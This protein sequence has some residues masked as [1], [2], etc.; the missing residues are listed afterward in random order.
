MKRVAEGGG[1]MTVIGLALIG[2]TFALFSGCALFEDERTTKGRK[3][4]N[5]YCSHCHGESGQQGEGFNWDRMPDPRPKNLA[6]NAEM[7]TF[8]DE[9]IFHTVYRD[10][11]DTSDQKVLNDE[12][13]FAVPTMPTFKYTLSEEEIW[14]IVGYV[15]TLHGMSLTYDLEGRRKELEQ[16]LQAA[17]P[18]METAK[19]AYDAAMEKF[20]AE[21]AAY[22][23]TLTDA[24]LENY[25]PK[26]VTLP[27]ETAFLAANEKYELA[28]AELENF[29][30][31]P[32]KA[33]VSRPELSL[34]GEGR[35]QQAELGKQLYSL[36]Y[37]CNGC[38]SLNDEGGLVGPALDRAGFRL[39]PTWIYRWIL[40]PQAMKKHTR[41]PN[42]G[43]SEQDAKALTYYLETLQAPKPENPSPSVE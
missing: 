29:T 36:K 10:M 16:A 23:E 17:Q 37:G 18:E 13:Y 38:H 26:D 28:K 22:E 12:N 30:K 8:S 25:E 35:V 7:S 39:N 4:Y 32:K 40:Y 41:M 5:H 15:R 6:S 34:A 1:D 19:A 43:I 9:E 14:A 42:L 3:L 11:K 27:E 2:L 20:E 21:Q 31:R 24:Q 33:Q